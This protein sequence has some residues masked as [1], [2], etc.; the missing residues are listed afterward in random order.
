MKYIHFSN[1]WW[2]ACPTCDGLGFFRPMWQA[3][4]QGIINCPHCGQTGLLK[5]V[6]IDLNQGLWLLVDRRLGDGL[7]R[8]AEPLALH[9]QHP[10]QIVQAGWEWFIQDKHQV[11]AWQVVYNGKA[12]MTVGNWIV[13]R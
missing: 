13:E 4:P 12:L 5:Q 7:E 8:T 9:R 10:C 6:S 11:M 2:Q 3:R 1:T